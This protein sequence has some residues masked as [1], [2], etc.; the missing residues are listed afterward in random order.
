MTPEEINRQFPSGRKECSQCGEEKLLSEFHFQ[1][2]KPRPGQPA[3]EAARGR[4]RSNCKM[5]QRKYMRDRRVAAIEAQ[6]VIFLEDE[7]RRVRDF[8][9]THPGRVEIRRAV[10]RAR[11]SAYAKLRQRHPNEFDELLLEA[12]REEGVPNDFPG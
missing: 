11:Y 8:Y 4:Y 6:G 3:T 1:R 7:T 9:N 5:C 12:R 2:Y 10:D